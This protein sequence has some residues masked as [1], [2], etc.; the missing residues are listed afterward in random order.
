M[1]NILDLSYFNLFISEVLTLKKW[2]QPG[3]CPA[4]ST[5]TDMSVETEV[6]LGVSQV[7]INARSCASSLL[8]RK[9]IHRVQF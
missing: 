6:R 3:T 7:R 9:E 2:C 5:L 1:R 4:A 8:G